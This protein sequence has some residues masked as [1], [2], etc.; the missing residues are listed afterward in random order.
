MYPRIF[1]ENQPQWIFFSLSHIKDKGYE[2]T[3]I[4]S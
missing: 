4:A 1:P 2:V 3:N